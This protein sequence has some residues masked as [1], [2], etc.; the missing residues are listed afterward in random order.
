MAIDSVLGAIAAINAELALFAAAG[1]LIGGVDDLAVDLLWLRYRLTARLR[2]GGSVERLLAAD[3]HRASLR[4]A[5]FVPAWDEAPVI[6][7]MI[8]ETLRR[9][10]D[11]N[12][13]L[14]VG[15]YPN[16]PAT[17]S[18][19]ER[20]AARSDK[21]R[22]AICDRPGPTT[23]ADCLNAIWR[24]MRADEDEAGARFDAIVLH[25]AEDLVHAAELR[26]YGALIAGHALVQLPVLPLIDRDSRWM[27]GHYCDEFAEAHGKNLVVREMLGAA[28]PSA[29][30]GCA[31]ARD[32]LGDIA[33]ERGGAPFDETSL[34]EDYELGLRIASRGGRSCFV[35]AIDPG[36]GLLVAVRA[37]FP[38]KYDAAVR[39]KSRWVMGIALMGW[40]RLGWRGG[41]AELWMRWR[42]RLAPVSAVV[43]AAAYLSL[44]LSVLLLAAGSLGFRPRGAG[45]PPPLLIALTGLLSWRLAMRAL[46]TAH[47]YDWREGV[48]AVPRAVVSNI[49]AMGAARRAIACYLFARCDETPRWDKTKH[50]FPSI[51]PSSPC[52]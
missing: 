38:R 31:I 3:A 32:M 21:V 46:F 33:D 2:G 36:D 30:V 28:L 43:V 47:A 39:Q 29:G 42:D 50:I 16:D 34:T 11:Q 40:D 35:R 44:I 17:V 8:E 10:G 25:D 37:L 26:L 22:L 5:V 7:S 41:L 14:Y 51:P 48:R 4:I 27:A 45:L 13:Q 12:Y 9:F 18:A 52:G 20:S 24:A 49:V 6:G 15:C 1:F 19:V 23:K